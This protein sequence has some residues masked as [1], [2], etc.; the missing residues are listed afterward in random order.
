MPDYAE[1]RLE[2]LTNVT[3]AGV[4]VGEAVIYGEGPGDFLMIQN[5]KDIRVKNLTFKGNRPNV[6]EDVADPLFSTVQL[7]GVNDGLVFDSCRFVEFGNHAISHLWGPKR[8][9]NLVVTNCYFADGGDGDGVPILNEDG[10]AISGI[11]SGSRIVNNR[12][13]RCF[14]GI[15]VEGA[16]GEWVTNVVIEGNVISE[17]HSVGIMV[18]AT[19]PAGENRPE[20]YSDIRILNNQIT[21]SYPHPDYTVRTQYGMMICGGE[22][23][24][25]IGNRI[26]GAP[27]GI[28]L[29]VGSPMM[30]LV[31]CQII[32]NEVR[33]VAGRGIQVWQFNTNSLSNII[34]KQNR[35]IRAVEEG[36]LLN[37]SGIECLDNVIENSASG[38]VRG[39]IKLENL[40][41][42]SSEVLI[43]DNIV[44][45]GSTNYASY[46]IWLAGGATNTLIYG[47]SFEAVK[48][49][50]I[51]DEGVNSTILG[52]IKEVEK[53]ESVWSFMVSGKPRDAYRL[54]VSHDLQTWGV[55][56]TNTCPEDG[57]FEMEYMADPPRV[58]PKGTFFRVVSNG[59]ME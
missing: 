10:A 51:R 29:W 48:T 13:E 47:N 30:D 34:V 25:I 1:L 41:L 21:N 54:E 8:S 55:V 59:P 4:G 42:G 15:E 18:L 43:A 7:R 5:S 58:S 39:A 49:E 12:I 40:N 22:E 44:R 53:R 35:I 9:Y 16:F 37:G 57:V 11:P 14:R 27:R 19:D 52:K 38:G 26:E 46:G 32:S 6:P 2:N 17:C 50:G 36:I 33:S 23:I 28:G 24:Q 3:I 31:S 56:Q 20:R 45:N